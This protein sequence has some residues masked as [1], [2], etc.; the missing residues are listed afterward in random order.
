[1]HSTL[2][3][4]NQV[5]KVTHPQGTTLTFEGGKLLTSPASHRSV[6]AQFNEALG[7]E[8]F[9]WGDA[10]AWVT[11][12]AGIEPCSECSARRLILN[13]AKRLGIKETIRQIRETFHG[14]K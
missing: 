14:S 2:K 13:Q 8:G 1:M 11:S 12:K 5:I 7:N 4:G 3:I 6:E 9:Q 10:V